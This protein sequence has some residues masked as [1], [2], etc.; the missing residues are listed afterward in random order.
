MN[1]SSIRAALLTLAACSSAGAPVSPGLAGAEPSR[2]SA[3]ATNVSSGTPVRTPVRANDSAKSP[4]SSAR[5]APNFPTWSPA[6]PVRVRLVAPARSD[7]LEVRRAA[8]TLRVVRTG[9][10]VRL[11][12]NEPEREVRVVA[13]SGEQ[14]LEVLGA[15]VHGELAVRAARGGGLEIDALVDLERYVEGVLAGELSL[16]S[17]SPA[18]I[19][20]QAIAARSYAVCALR[21]RSQRSPTPYLFADTRDQVFEGPPQL[22]RGAEARKVAARLAAALAATRGK[23]LLEGE[24]VVD[25]RF[26]AS[27]GGRTADAK[28]FAP[29]AD[30]DC[31]RPVECDP[32]SDDYVRPLQAAARRTDDVGWRVE[33][34]ADELARAFELA[35][36]ITA[37]AATRDDGRGRWLAVEAR[38]GDEAR[39]LPF[40]AFRARIGESR[41]ASPWLVGVRLDASGRAVLAGRGK[42]H[43]IG[44]CQRGARGLAA[45]GYGAERILD[46]YF[47]GAKV[48]VLAR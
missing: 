1:A 18:E 21:E 30:F 14:A 2:T 13:P 45:R 42:G 22:G 44:L 32:C 43:G 40:A 10:L 4:E 28:L 19:E 34:G 23:V 47:P 5:P 41:L 35:P 27:C 16:W 37:L 9:E 26:S 20:A 29:E 48:G 15:R 36:P 38:N 31:L 12:A 7:V 24:R 33:L 6:Q 8:A 17:A 25:A 46:H 11:G 3:G 39:T